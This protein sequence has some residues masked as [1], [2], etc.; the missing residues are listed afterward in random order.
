[1]MKLLSSSE[2]GVQ[3]LNDNLIPLLFHLITN[4]HPNFNAL[5][6]SSH[7]VLR[8]IIRDNRLNGVGAVWDENVEA[9]EEINADTTL[10]LQIALH[11]A[12]ASAVSQ[13]L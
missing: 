2:R 6:F 5:S 9:R 3:L 13:N 11:Y 8:I 4:Y 7:R 1:M 12:F 10:R